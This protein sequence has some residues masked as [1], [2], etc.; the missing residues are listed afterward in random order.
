MEVVAPLYVPVEIQRPDA[1]PQAL[2]HFHLAVAVST[3][4]LLLRTR[5]PEELAHGPLAVRLHLPLDTGLPEDQAA[6]ELYGT[7]DEVVVDA[8]E[9]RE[10]TEPR[11]VRFLGLSTTQEARILKYLQHRLDSEGSAS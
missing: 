11:R 3:A 6:L 1:G 2:R 7:A 8:G 5:L 9:E 10:R 4:G